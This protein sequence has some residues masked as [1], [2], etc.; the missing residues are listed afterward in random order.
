[1]SNE[2]GSF[3]NPH[4]KKCQY[5][6]LSASHI[7]NYMSVM[8]DFYSGDENRSFRRGCS[9]SEC[10]HWQDPPVKGKTLRPIAYHNK[11]QMG[12]EKKTS[13]RTLKKVRREKV[14]MRLYE[15]G[16]TDREIAKH[17]DVG[18]ISPET[19]RKW[20][21]RNGLPCLQWAKSKGGRKRRE[22]HIDPSLLFTE[23]MSWDEKREYFALDYEAGYS[24]CE[25]SERRGCDRSTVQKWRKKKGLPSQA[26][27]K[28][29]E[30]IRKHEVS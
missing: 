12:K 22:K 8:M 1:M 4:C 26:E 17:P 10:K 15:E 6:E 19:V 16:K 13:S 25:I 23:D 28:K 9:I 7:C 24:D 3:H 11:P 5:R 27:R 21:R 29:L 14:Q 30:D 2:K 20:R 18:G